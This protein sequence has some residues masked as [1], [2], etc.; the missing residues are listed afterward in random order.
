MKKTITLF[1]AI[2]FVVLTMTGCSKSAMVQN[3]DNTQML[4]QGKSLDKV[5]AAIVQGGINKGWQSKK[6][7]NGHIEMKIVVKGTYLVVVDALYDAKGYELVYKDSQNLDYNAQDNTIHPSYNKW[8]S[9]LEREINH[10]LSKDSISA[11]STT[12][13]AVESGL[14][15]ANGSLNLENQTIYIQALA[16]YDE[17]AA[18]AQNIKDECTINK[19]L[20]DFIVEYANEMNI[21]VV[22]TDAIPSGGIELRVVIADAVS[23]GNAFIGHRKYSIVHGYL[24]KDKKRYSSFKAARM[25]GGGAF[26]GYKGSCAVLGRTV[27]AIGNDI[28]LWLSSPIDGAKLGDTQFLR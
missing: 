18:I 1:A 10:V 25:S 26:G 17:N 7:K 13:K 16:P 9:N 8:V 19:Q 20:V 14:D 24:V 12:A 28:A 27:R 2:A 5:E 15:K 4:A 6:V 21:K 3:I 23:S 11:S 22:A